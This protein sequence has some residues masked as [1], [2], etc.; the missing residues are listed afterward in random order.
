MYIL[1]MSEEQLNEFAVIL[2]NTLKTRGLESL[3]LV[4][5]LNNV[6]LSAKRKENN[7]KEKFEKME[8]DE[9]S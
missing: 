7:E 1:E 5:D 8:F 3:A 9:S 6:L 4:V 2:D